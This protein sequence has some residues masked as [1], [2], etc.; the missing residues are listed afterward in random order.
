MTFAWHVLLENVTFQHTWTIILHLDIN[1]SQIVTNSFITAVM[2]VPIPEEEACYRMHNLVFSHAFKQ[3]PRCLNEELTH[4]GCT[5]HR[6]SLS[7]H[8]DVTAIPR[9]GQSIDQHSAVI[10]CVHWLSKQVWWTPRD[11]QDGKKERDISFPTIPSQ[12]IHRT[13]SQRSPNVPF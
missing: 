5:L 4:K 9:V 10:L 3:N 7:A 8:S 12:L 1:I 11:G 2:S 6:G 13:S